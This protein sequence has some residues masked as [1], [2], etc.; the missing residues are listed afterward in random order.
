M[1]YFHFVEY[2]IP[3]GKIKYI[4]QHQ[5]DITIVHV[6]FF[7]IIK[8]CGS[9]SKHVLQTETPHCDM[10]RFSQIKFSPHGISLC[11]N[12]TDIPR[13]EQHFTKNLFATKRHTDH[14]E[15]NIPYFH[16]HRMYSFN[17][18]VTQVLL[19]FLYYSRH[20][21]SSNRPFDGFRWNDNL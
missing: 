7:R 5:S 14:Y 19:Q 2:C 16:Q 18:C 12:I 20:C 21:I 1:Q 6:N 11:S 3:S 10:Q 13:T 9:N 17:N 15:Q 8:F 4:Q